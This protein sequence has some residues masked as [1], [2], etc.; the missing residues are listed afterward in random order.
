VILNITLYNQLV[1]NPGNIL[2]KQAKKGHAKM[3][4]QKSG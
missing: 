4:K 1:Y 2:K 3:T